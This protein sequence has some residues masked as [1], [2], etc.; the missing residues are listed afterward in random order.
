MAWS[1]SKSKAIS[2][3]ILVLCAQAVWFR[4]PNPLTK[5]STSSDTKNGER[6]HTRL[7]RFYVRQFCRVWLRKTWREIFFVLVREQKNSRT[8]TKFFTRV[9]SGF[10]EPLSSDLRFVFS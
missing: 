10:P 1:Y 5:L 8:K 2:P 4:W 9:F 3:S 7:A 6:E